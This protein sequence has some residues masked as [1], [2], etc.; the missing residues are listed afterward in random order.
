MSLSEIITIIVICQLKI[1]I[2]NCMY[3]DYKKEFSKIVSHNRFIE[4]MP[5]VLFYNPC[6]NKKQK[7]YYLV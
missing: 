7:K 5:M 1:F 4:L 3:Q 6:Q 2:Y